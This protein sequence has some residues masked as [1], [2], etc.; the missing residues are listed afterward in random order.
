[1][2]TYCKDKSSGFCAIFS[3]FWCGFYSSAASIWG[4]LICNV[5]TAAFVQFFQLFGAAFIQVRLLFEDGLYAM[6]WLWKARE[7]SLTQLVSYSG[8]ETWLFEL[9]KTV[10]KCKYTFWHAKNVE[11]SSPW[12]ILGRH[13]FSSRGFYLS[14]A[15]AQLEFGE[16]AASIWVQLLIKSGTTLRN[17]HTPDSLCCQLCCH[18]PRYNFQWHVPANTKRHVPVWTYRTWTQSSRASVTK[19]RFPCPPSC[20]PGHTQ[21]GP[22]IT[23]ILLVSCFRIDC[24]PLTSAGVRIDNNLQLLDYKNLSR[25]TF[26]SDKRNENQG[27]CCTQF[28]DKQLKVI[29]KR[30]N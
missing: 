11:L 2:A 9:K 13:W 20:Q 19:P 1:M 7:S 27:S 8:S 30:W 4:R 12:T 29:E 15:Y 17:T 24:T 6:F 28:C 10:S 5:L 22:R 26:E 25:S 18:V 16:S 21:S 14:A 3:T 23:H